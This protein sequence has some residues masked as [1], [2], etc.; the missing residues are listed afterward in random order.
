MD[1]AAPTLPAGFSV[2]HHTDRERW[3]GCTVILAPDDAVAAGEVRGGGPGT[4]EADLLLPG[5]SAPGVQAVVFAGGSAFGLSAADGVVSFL[6]ERG[7]GYRTIARPVPLVAGAIVYDLMLGDATARPTADDAYAA[8]RDAV[9]DPARG[10]VGAGTGCTAGTLLGLDS[11]TK[12]GL[13][14][15]S[16]DAGR[17]T[18][19]ALAVANPFGDVVGAD[20]EVLAGVRLGDGFARTIDLLGGGALPELRPREATTLVCVMTDAKLTKTEAWLVAR[21]ATAGVARAVVPSATS[22]DGDFACCIASG[23]V[24]APTL[25]VSSLAAEATARAV[26]DAVREATGAPGC[27]ALRD[28]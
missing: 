25:V 19:A 22:F 17:A 15:A 1:A 8:C 12:G 16:L 3:T 4:R 21:A 26:R 13:G 6:E 20:G 14:L 11:W 9:A 27:P 28:L 7:R 23:T 18:V 2:G 24:E 10:S 5:A